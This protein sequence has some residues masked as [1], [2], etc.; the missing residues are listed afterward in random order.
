VEQNYGMFFAL[1]DR[2]NLLMQKIL[3]KNRCWAIFCCS[4]LLWAGIS[5]SKSD[6]V[7]PCLLN[8][9]ITQSDSLPAIRGDITYDFLDR[10]ERIQFAGGN[11]WQYDYPN[12]STII[13][14]NF[15]ANE[16]LLQRTYY[17]L[18][19]LNYVKIATYENSTAQTT[20]EYNTNGYLIKT[21]H[22]ENGETNSITRTIENGNIV[23][24][25]QPTDSILYRETYDYYDMSNN[26]NLDDYGRN[27]FGKANTNLLRQR[28]FLQTQNMQTDTA[29]IWL[30]SY[31]FD[32]NNQ[33]IEQQIYT[34]N[35]LIPFKSIS[36]G[37][38]C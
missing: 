1:L 22:T 27:L 15:D 34:Q 30:Y 36:Y 28:V 31:T 5:C 6:T 12:S 8:S 37:Y 26:F 19:Q 11:F 32:E 4:V 35:S 7:T 33:V 2:K 14:N 13:A 23:L 38:D 21:N 16:V 3:L 17:V 18:N 9:V 29:A 10:I 24:L 25:V 20:Y